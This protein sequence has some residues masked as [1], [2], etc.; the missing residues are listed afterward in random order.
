MK[1]IKTTGRNII[2]FLI[3]GTI[4]C[5]GLLILPGY[6][7]IEPSEVKADATS[8][9]VTLT[10]SEEISITPPADIT[11]S[12]NITMSA[13]SSIGTGNAWNVKTSSQA[14]Y[15]LTLKNDSTPALQD[16]TTSEEFGDYATSSPTIWSV[17]SGYYQFGF[18]VYGNDINTTTWGTGSDCGTAG[19]P[20]GTLKYSGFKGTTEITVATSSSETGSSGTDTVMCVAAAQN[21]IYAPNGVYQTTI[22]GTAT[23]Q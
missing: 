6:A 23:A 4:I 20:S 11:M 2:L 5:V 22:T 15:S 13:N 21:T 3:S 16:A 8:T 9:V 18:S 7:L 14:G 12:P 10:V 17:P 1:K 19:T